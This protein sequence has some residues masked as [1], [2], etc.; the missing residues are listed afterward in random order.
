[1]LAIAVFDTNTLFSGLGWKG[2]PFYCLQ[3]AR[4][5]KVASVTCREILVEL[6]T[7]LMQ[8]RGMS[9]SQAAGAVLE[10][11]LCSRLV[12]IT[13]SLKTVASDPDDDKIIECAVVGGAT[14]IVTG[15]RRHLLPLRSYQGISIVNA[16]DFLT[17]VSTPLPP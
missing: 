13:H 11:L 10:I 7:K 9:A 6:E 2:A 15:D 16:R 4:Q 8:K 12:M 17:L 14:H 3:L 1:M 5:R